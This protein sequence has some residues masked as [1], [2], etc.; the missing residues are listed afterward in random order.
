MWS[1]WSS[2]PRV[3]CEKGKKWTRVPLGRLVVD[4]LVRALAARALALRWISFSF[5]ETF[6]V[7][8]PHPSP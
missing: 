8:R 2:L 4:R 1:A 7:Y 3:Y 6:V 5:E